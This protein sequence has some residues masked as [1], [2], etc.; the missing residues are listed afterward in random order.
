MS[1][2]AP[3]PSTPVAIARIIHTSAAVAAALPADHLR[4][5]VLVLGPSATRVSSEVLLGVLS[6]GVATIL[7]QR[8][9]SPRLTY[10]A[11]LRKAPRGR[12]SPDDLMLSDA[13]HVV[14]AFLSELLGPLLL[15]SLF[16]SVVSGL[17]RCAPSDCA[18]LLLPIFKVQ[19]KC[20]HHAG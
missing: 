7:H 18:H 17:L 14:F 19:T 16:L 1:I 9:L 12:A 2:A 15:E 11:S 20:S 13:H 4:P 8:L 6:H 3:S 5:S 10:V